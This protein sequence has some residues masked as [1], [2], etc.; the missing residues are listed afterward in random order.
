MCK[1]LASWLIEIM[2][3]LYITASRSFVNNIRKPIVEHVQCGLLLSWFFCSLL[4]SCLLAN[5][6][7][8]NHLCKF[9][10]RFFTKIPGHGKCRILRKNHYCAAALFAKNGVASVRLNNFDCKSTV[11]LRHNKLLTTGYYCR[12]QVF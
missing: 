4:P 12:E 2:L 1:Y 7:R 11:I 10:A 3:A 5:V 8:Q 9:R 6:A